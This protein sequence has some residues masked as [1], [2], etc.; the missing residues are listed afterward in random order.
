MVIHMEVEG[1]MGVVR[2]VVQ[3]WDA[4]CILFHVHLGERRNPPKWSEKHLEVFFAIILRY[5]ML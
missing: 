3:P 2:V 5:R 1:F 4:P